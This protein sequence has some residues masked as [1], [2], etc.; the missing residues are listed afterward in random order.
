MGREFFVPPRTHRG[1][2]LLITHWGLVRECHFARMFW[3]DFGRMMPPSTA[4]AASAVA[5]SCGSPSHKIRDVGRHTIT[6][7]MQ[8]LII[9][10]VGIE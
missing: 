2:K 3:V 6:D 5:C 1:V 4:M 10:Y 8:K 9:L 7:Q